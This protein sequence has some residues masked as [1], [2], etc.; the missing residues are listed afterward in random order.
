M[1]LL[2]L[3]TLLLRDGGMLQVHDCCLLAIFYASKSAVT[4]R[5][6]EIPPTSNNWPD[7]AQDNLR[8]SGRSSKM[9]VQRE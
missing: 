7:G 6:T 4:F 2:L 8:Y 1:R 3:M 9:S 5:N